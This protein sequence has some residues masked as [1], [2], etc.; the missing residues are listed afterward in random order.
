MKKSFF[1]LLAVLFLT[2]S[3]ATVRVQAPKEP[4]KMDIAMRLDVYQHVVK[5]IDDIESMVSGG[6]QTAWLG[7]LFI[8][9]AYA[10]SLS[11]EIEQ[12]VLRRKNRRDAVMNALSQGKVG[13]GRMGLLSAR[14]SSASALVGEENSD[15]MAIYQSLAGSNQSPVSEIQRVYAERLQKDAP[16]GSYIETAQGWIQK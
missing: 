1:S 4:I 5:Q 12:A 7:E 6:K 16:G 14:D 10:E 3:C 15:R 13:E 8:Q 11:P 9:T 2:A